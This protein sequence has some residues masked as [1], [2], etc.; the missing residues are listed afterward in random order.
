[1][2]FGFKPLRI[3]PPSTTMPMCKTVD[4]LNDEK[5][6]E[7]TPPKTNSPPTSKHYPNDTTKLDTQISN[8]NQSLF[9]TSSYPELLDWDQHRTLIF[10][11]FDNDD[12]LE[13]DFTIYEGIKIGDHKEA[14]SPKV[15]TLAYFGEPTPP[16]TCKEKREKI[17]KN[18]SLGKN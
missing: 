13:I 7:D 3:G 6:S 9:N 17:D 8:F 11:Q 15:N 16:S 14:I 12:A 4:V 18:R 1:M 10:D 2:G 5:T